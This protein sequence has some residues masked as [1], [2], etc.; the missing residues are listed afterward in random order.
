MGW[1][2]APKKDSGVELL[3]DFNDLMRIRFEERVATGGLSALAALNVRQTGYANISDD[4]KV[5]KQIESGD[6][7]TSEHLQEL[8]HIHGI[9]KLQAMQPDEF[10]SL[11]KSH[12]SQSA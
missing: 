11:Y 10:Y 8:A 12:T 1:L 4:D 2:L 9:E 3:E 5:A 6:Q 7:V